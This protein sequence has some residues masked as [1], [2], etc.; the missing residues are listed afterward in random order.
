MD[1]LCLMGLFPD[2]Y[3]N[4]ILKDSIGNI[5]YAA[6]KLQWGIVKG[7][8]VIEGIQVTIAN[9]LFIGSYP[10]LYR[11]LMIPAFD[12]QC[13]SKIKGRNVHFCNLFA[14]K[15]LSRYFN[16]KKYVKQWCKQTGDTEKILLIYALTT[17]FL[18]IAKYVKR[19]FPEVVI[20]T[21]VPDLPE[22]MSMNPHKG[23]YRYLK[24]L[25]S[26]ELRSCADY[27]DA[28]VLLVDQM[29]EWFHHPITYTVVEGIASDVSENNSDEQAHRSKTILYAGGL[30]EA[31]GVV[32]LVK[33]FK[34]IGD[35]DWDLDIYGGGVA[36]ATL[37]EL[38]KGTTNIHLKG[39]VPNSEVVKALKSASILVNPRKNQIFTKYSFPSKI[40][41]YMSSGTAVMAYKLEGMPNEYDNY[42][43]RIEEGE[44]G[45]EKTLHSV[46]NLSEEERLEM[47]KSAQSFVLEQKNPKV[48]CEKI[49]N[50]LNQLRRGMFIYR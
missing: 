3:R 37:Q 1:I 5:Q 48:Q 10:K 19:T 16:A 13:S 45:L 29:K 46:M 49:I 28:F 23:L 11:K 27:V 40:L 14:Y 26:E 47:G 2:E 22:Y 30:N 25:I 7:L 9:C 33:A 41:E 43:Y 12:F 32:D 15:N 39:M 17:P 18:R 4:E 24:N 21:V 31:Y 44:N 35:N 42:F 20:C 6:D 38:A 36:L 34:E 50:M 8:D